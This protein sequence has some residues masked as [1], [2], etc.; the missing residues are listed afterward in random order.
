MEINLREY[1]RMIKKRLWIIV[2]SVVLSTIAAA[3]Y[4]NINYQ[5]VYQ[6]STKL[7]VNTVATDGNGGRGPIDLGMMAMGDSSQQINMYKEIIKTPAIM[8]KVAQRHPELNITSE[9]LI[10]SVNVTAVNSTPIMAIIAQ[11]FSHE[12]AVKI[13]NYV[14]EV[15]QTEMP[16]IMKIESITI[17]NAAKLTDKPSLVNKKSNQ[18]IILA[19]AA[20]LVVSIGIILFL[21]SLDDTLKT[22]ED[23]REVFNVM[24]LAMVPKIKDRELRV[25]KKATS[26]GHQMGEAQYASNNR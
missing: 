22:E 20:S 10:N 24:T 9:Q 8:E 3:Q 26:S 13:V 11:S 2:L 5:P 18:L 19:V 17:L 21:D 1:Y 15:F 16:K 6:A 14:T 7:I 12:R 4:S 23:I 25:K